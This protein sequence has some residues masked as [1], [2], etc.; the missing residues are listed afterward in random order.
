MEAP[1][2]VDKLRFLIYSFK[3]KLW[4]KPL[5][6]C[7]LSLIAVFIAKVA[8]G[9]SVAEHIPE[10]KSESVETLLSIMASRL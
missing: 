8:D 3:E 4:L 9:T 10:I 7:V 2:T 5:V 6:F 1:I